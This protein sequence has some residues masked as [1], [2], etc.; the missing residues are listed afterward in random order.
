MTE[1]DGHE[2]VGEDGFLTKFIGGDQYE[3]LPDT[4]SLERWLNMFN[5]T[6]K[7]FK[8]Y[9]GISP[10]F[11]LDKWFIIVDDRLYFE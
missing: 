4:D 1:T 7:S 5:W 6:P 9:F 3:K 10:E 11:V 8:K 2:Y